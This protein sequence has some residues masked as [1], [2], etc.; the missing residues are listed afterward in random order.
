MNNQ[1]ILVNLA[2]IWNL[3]IDIQIMEQTEDK[4]QGCIQVEAKTDK[5]WSIEIDNAQF[6]GD[7]VLV[8]N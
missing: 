1:A 7:F 5:K 3:H 2:P 8:S 4:R 6:R